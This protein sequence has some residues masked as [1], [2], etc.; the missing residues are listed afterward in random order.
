MRPTKALLF[1][2]SLILCGVGRLPAATAGEAD[3]LQ[4]TAD[5]GAQADDKERMDPLGGA[6]AEINQIRVWLSE[7]NTAIK[8]GRESQAR[9]II[10]RARAQLKLVDQVVVLSKI[11]A[12]IKKMKKAMKLAREAAQRTRTKL[13]SI[14]ARAQKLGEVN[15]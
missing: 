1:L 7:A 6:Q 9:R 3:L 5:L 15:P 13:K 12:E 4:M 2:A 8:D 11:N 14:Q 10:D